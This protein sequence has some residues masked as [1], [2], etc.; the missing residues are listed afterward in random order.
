VQGAAIVM[1]VTQNPT[2]GLYGDPGSLCLVVCVCC[3]Q[4]LLSANQDSEEGR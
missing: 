2:W 3:M 4:K 1:V